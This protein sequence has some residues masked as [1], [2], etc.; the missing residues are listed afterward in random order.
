ME[1]DPEE[2]PLEDFP[3]KLLQEPEGFPEIVRFCEGLKKEGDVIS[4]RIFWND[5]C[6]I[7]PKDESPFKIKDM[8]EHLGYVET[9]LQPV[10]SIAGGIYW[11][12]WYKYKNSA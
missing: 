2:G 12:H 4:K 8:F 9:D 1:P 3:K 7:I 10:P 5:Y 6:L 11:N